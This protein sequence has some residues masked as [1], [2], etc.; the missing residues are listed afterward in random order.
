MT[1]LL[2]VTVMFHLHPDAAGFSVFAQNVMLIVC[3]Y[4]AANTFSK[5]FTTDEGSK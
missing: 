5:K 1:S 4:A 3:G 2:G